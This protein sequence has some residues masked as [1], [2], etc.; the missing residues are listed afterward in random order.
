MKVCFVVGPSRSGTTVLVEHLGQYGKI[1]RETFLFSHLMPAIG[2]GRLIPL[3]MARRKYLRWI[4]GA[5]SKKTGFWLP[6]DLLSAKALTFERWLESILLEIHGPGES[7]IEKT[8]GHAAFIDLVVGELDDVVVI[9]TTRDL[10]SCLWSAKKA[11]WSSD[12][13]YR[14]AARWRRNH[15]NHD[16]LPCKSASVDYSNFSFL[17]DSTS[18]KRFVQSLGFTDE[19]EKTGRSYDEREPWKDGSDQPFEVARPTPSQCPK[20]TMEA[21]GAFTTSNYRP[22]MIFRHPLIFLRIRTAIALEYF[23]VTLRRTFLSLALKNFV[24]R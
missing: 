10:E 1:G 18:F 8:P 15:V 11:G 5:Y 21:I 19:I 7:R 22:S 2:F 4:Q 16:L 13:T 14:I 6:T 3:S 20:R 17:N 23:S 24:R 12:S 9:A